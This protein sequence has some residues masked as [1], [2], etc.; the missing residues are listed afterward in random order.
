MFSKA[1][2]IDTAFRHIR[3]FCI[4]LVAAC[5]IISCY[6]VYRSFALVAG[7]QEKIYILAGGKA[8]EA[9]AAERRDNIPVEARDHVK[10]FHHHFFTLGPDDKA[11]KAG[12]TKAL[13]LAD[14]S[15]KRQ[16]DNLVESNYYSNL[17]SGNVSQTVTMDSIEVDVADYPFRFRYHAVQE[18]TRPTSVAQRSLLTEGFL[19]SVPRSD[20]NPHGFLI[21]DWR[22]LENRDITVIPRQR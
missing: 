22:I 21:E 13:Y 7:M 12:I 5:M 15:A 8:I 4:A 3:V 11:I 19:R 6:A 20:N 10:M 9:F 16:Y 14:G 17:I 1:K 2:H 18:I